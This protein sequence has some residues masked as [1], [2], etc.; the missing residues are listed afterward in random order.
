MTRTGRTVADPAQNE[1][2]PGDPTDP[3]ERVAMVESH[4]NST[5]STSVESQGS[6]SPVVIIGAGVGF[7]L[8]LLMGATFFMS[9]GSGI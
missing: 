9:R 2:A 3:E 6:I 8:L 5:T 1:S 4:A 7:V